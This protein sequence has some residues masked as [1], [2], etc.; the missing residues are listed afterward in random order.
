MHTSGRVGREH[1]G[2]GPGVERE[3]RTG[4]GIVVAV[5]VEAFVVVVVAVVGGIVAVVVVVI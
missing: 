5:V 3:K 1:V 4:L 2:E